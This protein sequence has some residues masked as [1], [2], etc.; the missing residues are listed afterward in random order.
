VLEKIVGEVEPGLDLAAVARESPDQLIPVI[1][2]N[3]DGEEVQ[4]ACHNALIK[5]GTKTSAAWMR[6][7]LEWLQEQ[8]GFEWNWFTGSQA[9]PLLLPASMAAQAALV[10]TR[11][12]QWTADMTRAALRQAQEANAAAAAA[13]AAAEAATDAAAEAEAARETATKRSVSPDKRTGAEKRARM[14]EMAE[15]AATFAQHFNQGR[16]Q[17]TTTHG[18]IPKAVAQ[19]SDHHVYVLN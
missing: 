4:V 10:Q 11:T 2:T 5:L 18:T 6:N 7:Q 15:F 1:L 19:V 13:N 9:E 12:E 16:G 17:S 14:E 8:V 3:E